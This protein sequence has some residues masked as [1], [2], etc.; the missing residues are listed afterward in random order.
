M[1]ATQ[2][3]VFRANGRVLRSAPYTYNLH[4]FFDD[5]GEVVDVYATG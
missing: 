1:H 4:V 5:E 2:N 3:D